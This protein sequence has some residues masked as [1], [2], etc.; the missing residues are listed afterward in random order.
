MDC[1]G[2][3]LQD[4]WKPGD[5]E[6]HCNGHCA[7]SARGKKAS[8][9][10]CVCEMEADILC[11]FTSRGWC[12][13]VFVMWGWKD[14]QD[15]SVFPK[16]KLLVWMQ[17]MKTNA[18]LELKLEKH[19]FFPLTLS[20]NASFQKDVLKPGFCQASS[21]VFY[22][23]RRGCGVDLSTRCTFQEAKLNRIPPPEASRLSMET[24]KPVG[25]LD[26]QE[27]SLVSFTLRF[28]WG[29]QL[30]RS[31]CFCTEGATTASTGA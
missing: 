11:L 29:H 2:E 12:T 20:H 25:S 21:K 27:V 7:P 18:F 28:L 23:T 9:W 3:L 13:A 26:S 22:L 30:T 8:R 15:T 14:L 5:T 19:C 6:I 17:V 4:V 24:T 10:R 1:W 16:H 31:H